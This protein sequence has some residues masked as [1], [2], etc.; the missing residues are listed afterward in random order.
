MDSAERFSDHT[1]IE[2]SSLT[3]LEVELRSLLDLQVIADR[4]RHGDLAFGGD[5]GD[6]GEHAEFLTFKQCEDNP[7]NSYRWNRVAPTTS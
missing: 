3:E 1:E 2:P 5:R 7:I 4:L 6:G